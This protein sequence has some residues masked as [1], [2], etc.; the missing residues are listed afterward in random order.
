MRKIKGTHDLI[1]NEIK[2]WQIVEKK[3]KNIVNIYNFQEI[4]TPIIEYEEIFNISSPNSEMVSKEIFH[5]LDKKGRKIVLRPEG[6]ASVVRS[7][8]ENKLK[9]KNE[10]YK[11][12]YYGPFFRYERPQKGRYRQFTQFGIEIIGVTNFL[13]EIEIIFFIQEI[14]N[15]F[16]LNDQA[17]IKINN[18]G[19]KISR[20]NFLKVFSDYIQKNQ[21]K[22]CFLCSER[23]KKNILRIFD[24]KKC[25][26]KKFLEEAPIILDYLSNNAKINFEKIITIL[27]Q[28]K[29]NFIIDPK[30][31]R[32]LDYYTDLVFEVDVLLKNSKKTL[33]LGGGGNYNE[34]MENFSYKNMRN[35]GFAFG[36]ERLILLLE[37]NNF[38]KN[39]TLNSL[40]VFLFVL[41]EKL[42]FQ[43]FILLKEIREK[44]ISAEM[45]YEINNFSKK[46][47]KILLKNPKYIIFI[48]QKEMDNQTLT[49]KNT[50]TKETYVL[51]FCE[52]INFLKKELFKK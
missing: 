19:D 11:F 3:L 43:T 2:K 23:Q 46:L 32:G 15:F 52:G 6:T 5:F 45:N 13:S 40:D 44:K 31:V 16:N 8:I 17:L 4:R 18:L 25:S 26:K 48:G 49:I 27:K 38:F 36:M 29:I 7:Y 14:I 34:I 12:Y 24:C 41:D 51:N 35:I 22:L 20:Q 39:L 21:E 9:Q 50:L 37:E 28:F 47:K 30:L 42:F 1:F 10:L 33:S